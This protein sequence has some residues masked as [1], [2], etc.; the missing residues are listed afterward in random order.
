MARSKVDNMEVCLCSGGCGKSE[1]CHLLNNNL[2]T[3]CKLLVCRIIIL[4]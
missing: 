4:T 3:N 1:L 2:E